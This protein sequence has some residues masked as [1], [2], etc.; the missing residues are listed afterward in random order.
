[1][2]VRELVAQLSDL[3]P[4]S[5]VIVMRRNRDGDE[6]QSTITGMMTYRDGGKPIAE[7]WVDLL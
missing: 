3:S 4:D 2:K 1:V 7:L 5:E 6:I